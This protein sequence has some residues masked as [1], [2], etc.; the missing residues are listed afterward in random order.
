MT[1]QLV[2]KDWHEVSR[3]ERVGLAEKHSLYRR[4]WQFS[5]EWRKTGL[6][7]EQ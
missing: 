3:S 4:D 7:E 1:L 6:L 5:V 2:L